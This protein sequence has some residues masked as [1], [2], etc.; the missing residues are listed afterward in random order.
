MEHRTL[1]LLGL[2]MTQSQHGYQIHDFIEKNLTFITN[3]KKATAYSLLDKLSKEGYIDVSI[4]Y[5]GNRPP[6]KVYSINEN[7]KKQFNH[8]LLHNLT[9]AETVFY[10]G[11]IGLMFLDHLPA[12]QMITSLQTRQQKLQVKYDN[13]KQ[14]PSHDHSNGVNIAIRHKQKMM[15]AELSFLAETIQILIETSN[16]RETE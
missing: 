3:M 8:L 2:L 11:D 5:D 7:G 15:E 13:L 4:E 1:L 9:S 12:D 14:L 6:R 10:E 16:P